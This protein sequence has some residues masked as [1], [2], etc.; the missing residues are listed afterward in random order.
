MPLNHFIFWHLING[1]IC[2]TC[3]VWQLRLHQLWCVKHPRVNCDI[4]HVVVQSA[5]G[6]HLPQMFCST[7]NISSWQKSRLKKTQMIYHQRMPWERERYWER[8]PC[9]PGLN[10]HSNANSMYPSLP[11]TEWGQCAFN[12]SFPRWSP[13]VATRCCLTAC[14]VFYAPS[15]WTCCLV[16][17]QK[18]A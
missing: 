10:S 6:V 3:H 7:S 1:I 4:L 2:P 18:K 8:D 11:I 14:V 16:A 12:S 5:S 9:C 17:Q 15:S 13:A